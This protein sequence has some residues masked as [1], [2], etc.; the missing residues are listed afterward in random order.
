MQ[1]LHSP[2][3]IDFW[4]FCMLKESFESRMRIAEKLCS[5]EDCKRL[6][7]TLIN[8]LQAI[9]ITQCNTC[10]IVAS[11]HQPCNQLIIEELKRKFKE[12]L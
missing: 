2:E 5:K 6:F 8:N 7:D 4:V 12:Y 10:H 1:Q 3:P 9:T 11:K